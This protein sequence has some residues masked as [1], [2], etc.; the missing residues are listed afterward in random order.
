MDN[1]DPNVVPNQINGLP[2][3]GFFPIGTNSVTFKT[4]DISGNSTECT[5]DVIVLEYPNPTQTM[6][7]NDLVQ[8]TLG[9]DG[10]ALFNSDQ[11][12]EGGPYGCYQNYI[13]TV[14]NDTGLV[15][16]KFLSCAEIGND[17]IALVTNPANGNSCWGHIQL[18]DKNPPV[19][20]CQD[21]TIPCTRSIDEVNEPLYED[22]CDSEPILELTGV[23]P[24]E[25]DACDDNNVHFQRTWIATDKY[26]NVSQ[27]CIEIITI[28][29]PTIVDFPSDIVWQCE[30]YAERPKITDATRLR[31]NIV[32][33]DSTTEA[34]E[35]NP[36][37][38]GGQ[39]SSTGS[40]I[41]ANI[42][43]EFCKYNFTHSDDTVSICTG[44]TGVF[45]IIRT[46][47]VVDWCTGDVVITGVNGEDNVQIIKVMDS[48]PPTI[49]ATNLT[50]N[51]NV[52]G[53]HPLPCR[54]TAPFPS[55]GVTDNC[56]GVASVVINTQ[57]GQVVDGHIP[58]PGLP[59]GQHIVTIQAFD[60]C[61]NVATKDIVLNVIDGIA[62]TPVC[63]SYTEVDLESTGDAEVLASA[64]D[65][66]TY[67][68]CCLD[69]FLV[70]RMDDD[71]CDDG[72]NNFDFGPSVHFCCADAGKTKTV[73]MRAIDCFGNYNDCMVQVQVND[74]LFPVLVS[75]PPNQRISCDWYADN[76]ETQLANL[77]TATEK[78]E[79]LDQVFGAPTFYDNCEL[80]ITRNFT[81]NIDQCLDGTIT[82]S[83]QATDPAGNTTVQPCSQ[84]INVDHVSDWA[85]QFPADIS[86]NCGTTPPDFGEPTIF[87]ETCELV[88]VSYDDELFTVVT[89]ACYKVVR[90]WVVINW[91][92][93][94]TEVDQEVVEQSENQLGLPFPQCDLNGDGVCD[95][96]TFRDSW[97]S[98]SPSSN[99]RPTVLDANRNLTPD[100]DQDTDPWDGYITYQQVI[101]VS[102]TVD[103]V[104]V[105][106]CDIPMVCIND[107]TCG[108]IV[109][110][111][112]PDVL[113]CSA[114]LTITPKIKIGGVWLTG[115]GPYTNVPP[116]MYEVS[117][118][119]MDNCNNQ[120]VCNTT[121]KVKDCK[122]PTPYCKNGIIVTIMNGNPPMIDVWA[123]DLDDNSFDN[124][125]ND[126]IFS[127]GP[128]TTKTSL[129]FGCDKQNTTTIVDVWVTDECGNQDYC[130]T[131]ITVQD[132][133]VHA[134]ADPLIA[135]LG[136]LVANEDNQ[137][138]ENVEVNLGGSS[139]EMNL[140]DAVGL[141]HFEISPLGGDFS[142]VPS[143][144]DDPLNGVTTF[145][146]VLISKHILG[147]AP[148]G[149][150]YKIIAADAN[151]SGTVT[152][153]DMVEIRK[154]ILFMNDDFPNNTSWRFVDKNFVFPNPANPW[155]T[156]FPEF[157]NV[158]DLND[159]QMTVDFVGIKIGDVNGSAVTNA[160]GTGQNAD[161]FSGTDLVFNTENIGFEAGETIEV[162]INLQAQGLLGFQFTLN[163]DRRKLDFEGITE[164]QISKEFFG[165]SKLEDGA[166]NVSWNKS[167][168]S[169]ED[170]DGI[171][172]T[173]KFKA[174]KTGKLGGS[175][176]IDSRFTKSEAYRQEG[177]TVGAKLDFI[178]GTDLYEL[179]QNVPNPF[180]DATIIEFSLPT[181]DDCVFTFSDVSGKILKVI[182][183]SFPEGKNRITVKQS[184]LQAIGVIYYR[185]EAA[186]FTSTKMMVLMGK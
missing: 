167:D 104:F 90:T 136:G 36:N 171:V 177:G 66:A 21:W 28:Y 179:A 11:I 7:C 2:F 113:D 166:I 144:D 3:D 178:N 64:F 162:P 15:F 161:R 17:L 97:R 24:L 119:A 172:F 102:D 13:V 16:D 140:T 109:T 99:F 160:L 87:Y 180:S 76:L 175:V 185:M 152:T 149:S 56:S 59:I 117:Y 147:V 133:N 164:G 45:K 19:V 70:R 84:T 27:P 26:G 86:V 46:W 93:V 157:Q 79:L 12:L 169:A 18:E 116:G 74:K 32:D 184:E 150:P 14:T 129:T 110:L 146:L 47:T 38:S 62:P 80:D 55:P 148:L 9:P 151:K 139:N 159:D 103:P 78:S 54:S 10:L 122:K 183:G 138:I 132:N 105:N 96:R 57:Y 77:A 145:D 111:P 73:V 52:P 48:K 155:Q 30:Q 5:F 141:Y 63:I 92:V 114:N 1:C 135:N 51:A 163:F 82:R 85:V 91:C 115:I 6:A 75:C 25:I 153:F 165:F 182:Q 4:S 168:G 170:F 128:D 176:S 68:N 124:C 143:K 43:G 35:V 174:K 137:S 58:A 123:S 98:G 95:N 126:L 20:H 42:V 108:A 22:N 49:S 72:I 29:R 41:P 71:A 44:V 118:N 37:L 83:F 67:D 61:G 186:D 106:G 120:S 60:H 100:T 50:V 101:K 33:T 40:G 125:T 69:K 23:T 81:I 39:L 88:A 121:V 89:D 107:N 65:Q 130:T 127:F 8:M 181:T 34:I 154:L 53:V 134:C 31:S 173:L 94:G 158:N 142:V 131:Y 112:T 156:T